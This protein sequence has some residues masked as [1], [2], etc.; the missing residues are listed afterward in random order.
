VP[1]FQLANVT[2]YFTI[3]Q[4]L[5]P[6]RKVCPREKWKHP[7]KPR[8]V[9]EHSTPSE[10]FADFIEHRAYS[11]K[12]CRERLKRVHAIAEL[13]TGHAG[14]LDAKWALPILVIFHLSRSAQ[15]HDE[16]L[17][18]C[19]TKHQASLAN[20]LANCRL[21]YPHEGP[22]QLAATVFSQEKATGYSLQTR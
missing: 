2:F 4:A 13:E 9:G 20:N 3:D 17:P 18:W 14:S 7:L 10:R 16:L 1:S 6:I 12:C 22:C 5:E 8:V 15:G 19:V 21:T 11:F